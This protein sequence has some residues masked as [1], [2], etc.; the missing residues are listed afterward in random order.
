MAALLHAGASA[1]AGDV[2]ADTTLRRAIRGGHPL[3][4]AARVEDGAAVGAVNDRGRMLP[5]LAAA[6]GHLQSVG[7]HLR[8][9]AAVDVADRRGTAPLHLA[10]SGGHLRA[11]ARLLMNGATADMKDRGE[12]TRLSCLPARQACKGPPPPPHPPPAPSPARPAASV[13][14]LGLVRRP[15]LG[16]KAARRSGGPPGQPLLAVCVTVKAGGGT[17]DDGL[18]GRPR[19]VRV[20]AATT[21]HPHPPPPPPPLAWT[22]ASTWPRR[23][24][25]R[26]PSRAV[27]VAPAPPP[28]PL[29][30]PRPPPRG[31][32]SWGVPSPLFF[33]TG[34]GRV[35]ITPP[36]PPPPAAD[37]ARE[38]HSPPPPAATTRSAPG[39]PDV[40]ACV[41]R[42]R[43]SP[44]FL[45][46]IRAWR[47]SRGNV[48]PLPWPGSARSSACQQRSGA[49]TC[50]RCGRVVWRL[51]RAE[52]LA[53]ARGGGHPAW[54]EAAAGA[55]AGASGWRGGRDG[56]SDSYEAFSHGFVHVDEP[57]RYL[58]GR[59]ALARTLAGTEQ[60]HARRV[61]SVLTCSTHLPYPQHR[62][63][64]ERMLY[65]RAGV[66][67][68][69]IQSGSA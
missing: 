67:R 15:R 31:D 2:A 9:G 30:H 61:S 14:I 40:T 13:R 49:G 35:P 69:H 57:G 66:F 34:R 27:T 1:D 11:A 22:T 68:T 16:L 52:G 54:A 6:L 63:A 39:A 3:V 29:R 17:P 5:H 55:A 10:A 59:R 56:V 62:P 47:S 65:A 12:C 21:F 4:A 58:V 20:N 45:P 60:V 19:G 44:L 51:A 28:P 43:R 41:L 42:P 33:L 23:R 48:L 38:R 26:R 7:A 50:G 46:S 8:A 64:S 24:P 36:P 37:L 25:T 18:G 53:V 32:G